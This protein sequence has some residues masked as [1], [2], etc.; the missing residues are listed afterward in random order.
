MAMTNTHGFQLS[1]VAAFLILAAVGTPLVLSGGSGLGLPS[2]AP[3][4]LSASPGVG[5]HG[6]ARS[7]DAGPAPALTSPRSSVM[8]APLTR[9]PELRGPASPMA[10]A[11]GLLSLSLLQRSAESMSSA[12]PV[13]PDP[14]PWSQAVSIA[15]SESSGYDSVVWNV[16]DGEGVAL[17]SPVTLNATL[18]FSPELSC[19]QTWIVGSDTSVA[20]PSTPASASAGTATVYIALLTSPAAPTTTLEYLILNGA[21]AFAYGEYC[22]YESTLEQVH[23]NELPTLSSPT[24]VSQANLAGGGAYLSTN[25]SADRI[26]STVAGAPETDLTGT[27]TSSPSA[28]LVEY[29][30]SIFGDGCGGFAAE[31]DGTTGAVLENETLPTDGCGT[32]YAVTFAETGLPVGSDW[33]VSLAG[34]WNTSTTASIGFTEDNGTWDYNVEAVAGY[35][36]TPANGTVVVDGLGV[37]V[38]IVFVPASTG[39][40]DF[41]ATGLATGTY[42]NVYLDNVSGFST[43]DAVSFPASAG[44]HAY[45]VDLDGPFG[46]VTPSSGSVTVTA[47]ATTDV[48]LTF[49]SVTLYAVTFNE[50]GLPAGLGWGVYGYGDIEYGFILVENLTS[51]STLTMNLPDGDYEFFADS[52]SANYYNVSGVIPLAVNGTSANVSVAFTYRG[53][54]TFTFNE[55]GLA[56]GTA[57]YVDNG[58]TYNST[59]GSSIQFTLI[60]GSYPFTAGGA[61]GYVPVPASGSISVAGM[62]ANQTINFTAVGI[63]GA[64]GATFTESGL[65]SGTD[66]SVTLGGTERTASSSSINFTETNGT[67]DYTVASAGYVPTPSSGSILVTGAN[68]TQSISFATHVATKYVVAFTETGLT[69]GTSWSVTLGGSTNTSTTATIT[70]SEPNG[71]YTF[72]VGAVTGYTASPSS[73][74]VNVTGAGVAQP[75]TFTLAA[76]S[77]VVTFTETGLSTGTNWSVTFDSA[78]RYSSTGTISFTSTNGVYSY[79]IAS[80]SGYT[81]SPSSGSLTVSGSAVSESITFSTSS[82]SSHPATFLGLPGNDGYYIIGILA[83]L[84][85]LGIAL[86]LMRGRGKTG[87]QAASS[88]P[89][90]G[91]VEPPP[92]GTNP[93]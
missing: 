24:A 76:G 63:L 14:I 28:W 61:P 17:S 66:W 35:V 87:G 41:L 83:L 11:T 70:F 73:S 79:S 9:S 3:V 65:P 18:A 85:V 59:T 12:P 33:T 51:A 13:N 7:A 10:L 78:T 89:P 77:Y 69:A 46:N 72:T 31:I 25:A 58:F 22:P 75:I 37:I 45:G 32:Y 52:S 50:T 84:I 48:N 64:Y 71:T 56:P 1:I 81:A 16:T 91:S 2:A 43:T 90:A 19:V 5:L 38:P 55:T 36:P 44:I 4:V 42:W 26:W 15:L 60:N 92:P 40:V 20:L 21:V 49:A 39:T 53:A 8:T 93:P 67:Y 68:L 80:I 30:T 82:S 29:V 86:A 74:G 47:G 88:A 23:T 54:Y 62:A 34:G 27:W 6:L 57:W